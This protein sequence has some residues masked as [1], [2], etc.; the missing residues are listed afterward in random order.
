MSALFKF[1]SNVQMINKCIYNALIRSIKVVNEEY[2][3]IAGR[4]A[5]IGLEVEVEVLKE[6][7]R[8]TD[9]KCIAVLKLEEKARVNIFDRIDPFQKY[10]HSLTE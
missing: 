2:K 6:R 10:A 4:H 3:V 5:E 1:Y 7:A 9:K 8:Y